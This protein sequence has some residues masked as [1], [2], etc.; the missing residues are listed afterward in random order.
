MN[1]IFSIRPAIRYFHQCCYGFWVSPSQVL[2][3]I[4]SSDPSDK[5]IYR[6]LVD[7]FSA[8][9]FMMFHLWM[10]ILIDSLYFCRQALNCSIDAGFLHVDR[11]F[12]TNMSSKVSQLSMDPSGSFLIHDRA[13][14]LKYTW[15]LC[16]AVALVPLI[17]FTVSK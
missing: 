6:P 1:N 14:P 15:M 16:M 11:K 5:S 9:F 8:E 7:M 3:E 17:N 10:Y 12:L 4:F 2:D 13:V